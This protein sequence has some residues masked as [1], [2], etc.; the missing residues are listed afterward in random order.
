M[1][2]NEQ[3]YTNFECVHDNEIAH[4]YALQNAFNVARLNDDDYRAL[5]DMT[6]RI[7]T[8]IRHDDTMCEIV[9]D[10]DD[11]EYCASD[12]FDE[13]IARNYDHIVA[14]CDNVD[15]DTLRNV[16]LFIDDCAKMSHRDTTARNNEHDDYHMQFMIVFIAYFD[17]I[18]TMTQL[19]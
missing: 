15:R 11:D 14:S 8:K 1:N 3:R 18:E 12:D 17:Q 9:N 5:R 10:L 13:M 6:Q 4:V 2:N 19:R 7:E 16:A